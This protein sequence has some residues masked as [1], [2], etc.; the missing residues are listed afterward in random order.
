MESPTL[1][2]WVGDVTS[3]TSHQWQREPAVFTPE[4][5]ASPF[6]LD[7]LDAAFDSGLLRTP[8]LEMVRSN[9]VT[10]PADAYTTSRVVNGT[11]H[12]GFADRAKVVALL[13]AG[14]TLLLRHVD[15]WHR[16]T[17]DLVTRLS[18]ELD[19]RVEA[20][21][22]VTPADGQGLAI[23]RDD[24][25]VF[26]LQDLRTALERCLTEGLDVPERPLGEAAIADACA[27][28]LSHV[29]AKLATVEPAD[30]RLAA[31]AAQSRQLV[32]AAGAETFAGTARDW[33]AGALGAK[34]AALTSVV[35]TWR[36]LR[37]A[38]RTAD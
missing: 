18:G 8:Y 15:Q 14:A 17:G 3:F 35:R 19:R 37:G 38:A 1:A 16:P 5:L 24:A 23:H 34:R 32:E 22:F 27:T 9:K 21:F 4:T 29:G 13:R 31:R 26:A 30:L 2:D 28:L 7:E 25:D 10:V 6:D 36:R 12:H 20:F 11:T 33:E